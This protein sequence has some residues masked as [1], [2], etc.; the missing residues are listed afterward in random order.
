MAKKP[1]KSTTS[2]MDAISYK[3]SIH[4]GD[5]SELE[6]PAGDVG[7]M[8]QMTVHGKI[9]SKSEHDHGEGPKRSMSV[10]IHKI[11]SDSGEGMVADKTADGMKAA[12]DG[13]MSKKGGKKG[14]FA[15]TVQKE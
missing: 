4:F 10:E 1:K 12:M 11:G 2:P 14:G 3:P 9:A 8:V 15:K 13:A 7:D 6:P 5:D